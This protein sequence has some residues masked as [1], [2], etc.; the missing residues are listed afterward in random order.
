MFSST[1][2]GDYNTTICNSFVQ[3]CIPEELTSEVL[4]SFPNDNNA[5]E[6]IEELSLRLQLSAN[7]QAELAASVGN[8]FFQNASIRIRDTTGN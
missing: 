8:V 4:I 7:T 2:Q 1:E 6:G 5:S 3:L